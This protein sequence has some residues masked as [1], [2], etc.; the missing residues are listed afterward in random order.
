VISGD[1]D[2]DDRMFFVPRLSDK[3][4]LCASAGPPPTGCV[5]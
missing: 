4:Q 5:S 1:V 3:V 2:L